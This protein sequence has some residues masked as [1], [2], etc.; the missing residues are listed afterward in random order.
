MTKKVRIVWTR[1]AQDD[2]REI[3]R[4]IARDAPRTAQA[5]IRRLKASVDRLKLFPESGSMVQEV[6]N[7]EI[8]EIIQGNYRIIYRV[9]R[10]M[11]EIL[12]VF[13][14]ARLLRESDLGQ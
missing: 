13:H 11:V 7:P 14:S 5:F 1:Q 3:K 6:G 8:R 9:Q 4:F 12:T 10:K 2:L